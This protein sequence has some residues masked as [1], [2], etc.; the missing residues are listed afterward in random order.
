MDATPDR[1]VPIWDMKDRLRADFWTLTPAG[2]SM[3]G[4]PRYAVTYQ[5]GALTSP[6]Y[7]GIESRSSYGRR[8]ISVLE[9]PTTPQPR[10]QTSRPLP[11]NKRRRAH[12]PRKLASLAS[13]QED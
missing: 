4:A 5:I 9:T 2:V 1:W 13:I 10:P 12:E 3:S 6:P 8:Y 7:L 11:R